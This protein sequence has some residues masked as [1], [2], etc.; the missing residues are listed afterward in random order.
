MFLGSVTEFAAVERSALEDGQY[1]LY[2]HDL[3]RLGHTTTAHPICAQLYIRA[4]TLATAKLVSSVLA[5]SSAEICFVGVRPTVFYFDLLP[6]P[7]PFSSLSSATRHLGA[8]FKPIPEVQVYLDPIGTLWLAWSCTSNT[9]FPYLYE[10]YEHLSSYNG[11]RNCISTP[12]GQG[13][14]VCVS[15]FLAT[16]GSNPTSRGNDWNDDRQA[17][18]VLSRQWRPQR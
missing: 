13:S 8:C 9:T 17:C 1:Q 7:V 14:S 6:C 15:P 18:H 3:C 2:H 11:S 5:S 12:C 4:P 16:A 10:A